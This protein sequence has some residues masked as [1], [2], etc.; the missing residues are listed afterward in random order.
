MRSG[1]QRRGGRGRAREVTGRRKK[2]SGR[3]SGEGWAME[4]E[5]AVSRAARWSARL[6]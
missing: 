1:Q 2:L 6:V 3:R 4:E 5:R